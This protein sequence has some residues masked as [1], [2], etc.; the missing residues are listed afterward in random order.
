MNRFLDPIRDHLDQAAQAL[1]SY[2]Q[3]L[4]PDQI[5]LYFLGLFAVGCLL[6]IWLLYSIH[7]RSQSLDHRPDGAAQP[8][9]VGLPTFRRRRRPR[10]PP[11]SPRACS[12]ACGTV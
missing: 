1:W 7:R 10:Q 6:A 8:R 4:T 5:E 12:P 9:Q 11:P 2:V 3:G